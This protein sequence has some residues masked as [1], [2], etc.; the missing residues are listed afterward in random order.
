MTV[1]KKFNSVLTIQE[2]VSLT[3]KDKESENRTPLLPTALPPILSRKFNKSQA[4]LQS[5]KPEENEDEFGGEE[6]EVESS[7]PTTTRR[8]SRKKEIDGSK[9]RGS[10]T[11]IDGMPQQQQQ[12]QQTQDSQDDNKKGDNIPIAEAEYTPFP[13]KEKSSFNPATISDRKW[14]KLDPITRAKYEAYQKPPQEILNLILQSEI[15]AKKIMSERRQRKKELQLELEKRKWDVDPK[16]KELGLAEAAKSRERMRE[17]CKK[18]SY[19][20]VIL[21]HGTID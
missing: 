16:T 17:K 19:S 8:R 21:I 2:M 6:V 12:L 15:R 3:S 10:H 1:S 9:R 13:L 20:K 18:I 5:L 14:K 11:G 7:S 4:F